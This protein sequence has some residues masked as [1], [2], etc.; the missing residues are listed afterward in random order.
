VSKFTAGVINTVVVDIGSAPW[1]ANISANFQQIWNDPYVIFR[2]LG[3]IIYEKTWSKKSCDTVPVMRVSKKQDLRRPTQR[4]C[5]PL[6]RLIYYR[7]WRNLNNTHHIIAVYGELL[8]GTGNLVYN[9]QQLYQV[10]QSFE[11]S[12]S[13]GDKCIQLNCATPFIK[14]LSIN[15]LLTQTVP[16]IILASCLQYMWSWGSPIKELSVAWNPAS[17]WRRCCSRM[18]SNPRLHR[19]GS[20][21]PASCWW[22]CCCRMEVNTPQHGAGSWK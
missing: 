17:C 14:G 1:L 16:L 3:E 13:L 2:G 20:W 5:L 21:H 18:E 10:M 6:V 7:A 22:R 15:T 12:H 4:L 8:C 19:A 9:C 11:G